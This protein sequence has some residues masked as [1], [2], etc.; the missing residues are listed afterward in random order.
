MGKKYHDYDM[1][2]ARADGRPIEE[3]FIAKE[4]KKLCEDHGFPPVVFHSLRALSTSI[5]LQVS[6]GDIK[7]VQGDTGHSQS[8]MVTDVYARTFNE[9]RKKLADQIDQ[10]FFS[11]QGQPSSDDSV[12]N[13]EN[14]EKLLE[15]SPKIA[16]LIE[17]MTILAKAL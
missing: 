10:Q 1:V 8:N 13:V 3:R 2:T 14:L 6:G 5:K 17:A 11:G 9:N 12:T 15:D 4:M 16:K 7:A